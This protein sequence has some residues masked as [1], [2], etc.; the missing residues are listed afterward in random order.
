MALTSKE[1]DLSCGQ[2]LKQRKKVGDSGHRQVTLSKAEVLKEFI[3]NQKLL[4]EIVLKR[5]RMDLVLVRNEE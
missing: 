3:F 5:E 2:K 4:I 1:K